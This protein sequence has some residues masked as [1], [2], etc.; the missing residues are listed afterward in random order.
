MSGYFY[1]GKD[2][3]NIIIVLV[4]L[5]ERLREIVLYFFV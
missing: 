5:L 2:M 1:L 3:L 4:N